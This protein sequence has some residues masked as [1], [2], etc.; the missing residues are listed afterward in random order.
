[1]SEMYI[2]EDKGEYPSE[3]YEAHVAAPSFQDEFSDELQGLG[4]ESEHIPTVS[5]TVFYGRH[6]SGEDAKDFLNVF[7][8]G[9]YD[10]LGME[11][12]ATSNFARYLDHDFINSIVSVV[13]KHKIW[14]YEFDVARIR[15]G[16]YKMNEQELKMINAF[17]AVTKKDLID[18]VHDTDSWR[19]AVDSL[20]KKLQGIQTA[21]EN[22]ALA[23]A[24]ENLAKYLIKQ[25]FDFQHNKEVKVLMFI[26]AGHQEFDKKLRSVSD[27]VNTIYQGGDDSYCK[28]EEFLNSTR[29]FR[30]PKGMTLSDE[31]RFGVWKQI[32]DN[33]YR[34][35][36]RVCIEQHGPEE[37]DNWERTYLKKEIEKHGSVDELIRAEVQE[38]KKV[39]R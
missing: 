22:Y 26:G 9:K 10:V 2:N 11:L 28:S 7:H 31:W 23:Q 12:L 19:V 27:N 21:R 3:F 18:N 6:A 33:K 20:I 1:M 17:S 35:D 14:W 16:W 29:V 25:K 30:H 34:S 37:A 13:P 15:Y 8:Q 39:G 24:P 32:M 5:F 36:L 4:V 38:L